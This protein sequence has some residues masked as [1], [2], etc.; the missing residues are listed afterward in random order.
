MA[1]E[2]FH[3]ALREMKAG[4][5][6]TD[7]SHG[8][9]TFY[10][11]DQFDLAIPQLGQGCEI[12]EDYGQLTVKGSVDIASADGTKVLRV[13]RLIGRDLQDDLAER[14]FD[15]YFW[16][17]ALDATGYDT[18]EYVFIEAWASEQYPW[19]YMLSGSQIIRQ[20]RYP[21]LG[22]DCANLAARYLEAAKFAPQ[23]VTET[24]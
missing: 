11:E 24:T 15:S 8:L 14:C 10:T 16:R 20:H 18:F 12:E 2:A 9:F 22:S 7:L 13:Y 21:Q 19:D 1:D 6:E 3:A 4:D 17:F 23:L 5:E